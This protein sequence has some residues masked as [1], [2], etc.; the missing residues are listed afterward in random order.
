MQGY[1][2][3]VIRIVDAE[4]KPLLENRENVVRQ[5]SVGFL[6]KSARDEPHGDCG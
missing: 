5:G 1:Q 2:V 4:R 3:E 6:S